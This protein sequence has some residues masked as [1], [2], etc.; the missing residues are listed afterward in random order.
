[1]KNEE[2]KDI[3]GYEGLY[4]VSN[5]GR[6]RSLDRYVNNMFGTL[7]FIKGK[8][9]KVLNH[10]DGYKQVNLL[11]DGKVKHCLVHRLVAG[12]FIPNPHNYPVINHKDEIKTN[13]C[14]ENLEWCTVKHNNT[15]GTVQK[16]I[17]EK[18]T[19]RHDRSKVVIQFTLDGEFVGE[20]PSMCE[21]Q[22]QTG[23][24]QSQI[25]MCCNG[26]RKSTKGF[27]WKYK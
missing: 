21:A 24:R 18:L 22:R 7:S 3:E 25:S 16:R 5:M 26:I 2:W 8:I 15:Y 14:V 11:K 4:Q 6:V 27:I 12:A 20:Y 9:L 13:N 1:M 10:K 19:N 23:I 17:S